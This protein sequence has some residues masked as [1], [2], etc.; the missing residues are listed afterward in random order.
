M[1]MFKHFAYE[2]RL[3]ACVCVGNLSKNRNQTK[4]YDIKGKTNNVAGTN[5][6]K[7]RGRRRRKG[8]DRGI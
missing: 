4:R 6:A 2:F 5:T 3:C 8:S 7:S 1:Q